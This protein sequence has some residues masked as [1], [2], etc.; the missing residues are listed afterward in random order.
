MSYNKFGE[1]ELLQDLT[2]SKPYYISRDRSGYHVLREGDANG[3]ELFSPIDDNGKKN[4]KKGR[5][6]NVSL[7]MDLME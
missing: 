4:K 6:F 5:V 3:K 1:Q 2:K 7:L